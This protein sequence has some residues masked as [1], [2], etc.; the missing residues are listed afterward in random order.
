MAML[1]MYP[2]IARKTMFIFDCM[3]A[4]YTPEGKPL[5]LLRDDPSIECFKTDEPCATGT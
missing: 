2:A 5:F 3:D 1:V 4:G